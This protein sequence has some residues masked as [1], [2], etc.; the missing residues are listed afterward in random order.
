MYTGKK[1]LFSPSDAV[2]LSFSAM[3]K[4]TPSYK[5]TVNRYPTAI[6]G[7]LKAGTGNLFPRH[8]ILISGLDDPA[9]LI[10]NLRVM[11]TPD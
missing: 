9:R 5:L 3:N 2:Y 8:V 10:A 6:G 11:Q 1:N 4:C 7:W